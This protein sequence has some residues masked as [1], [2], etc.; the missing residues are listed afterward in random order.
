MVDPSDTIGD[1]AACGACAAPLTERRYVDPIGSVFFVFCSDRCLWEARGEQRQRRWAA[2]RLDTQ[3]LAVGAALLAAFLTRH[4]GPPG[5]RRAAAAAVVPVRASSDT[6]APTTALPAGWF[7]PEWPPTETSLLAALGE[8]AW[9]HPLS[10][11]VRRMPRSDSRVFGAPRPGDRAVE[12]RNGHC[13]VD[14]GGE[15]WGEQVHA[16]HDGVIDRVQRG[17]NPDHGGSYVRIAHRNGT[18]FTSYFHLAA[19]ARGLE[20][21]VPVKGGDVIGLLGDTG[22]KESTA[23]LHFTVS[24]KLASTLAEQYVDPEPLIAL[25]PLRIPLADSPVVLVSTEGPPGVPL[26]GAP[27]GVALGTLHAHVVARHKAARA[28]AK[29]EAH[30]AAEAPPAAAEDDAQA[31]ESSE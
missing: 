6:S 20:R 25:W 7:G 15:I 24:V 11:P 18:V 23:H 28:A 1:A 3:R 4:E 17:P 5:A 9:I 31:A 19:I 8:D 14:L 29:S 2:R 16:V 30:E 22:V 12:C 27:G 13:G 21:G 26:G 10:G